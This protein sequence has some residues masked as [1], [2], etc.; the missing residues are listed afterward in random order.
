MSD[1]YYTESLPAKQNNIM[2][3]ALDHARRGWPVFP[4]G[5]DKQPLTKHGFKDASLDPAVIRNWFADPA[6]KKIGLPTGIN[7]WALDV[8]R[9]NGVDG[10]LTLETLQNGETFT[11]GPAQMTPSGGY[12]LFFA[13]PPDMI[14]P[15]NAGQIGP[16]L[17]L[18]GAGGYVCTGPGYTWFDGYPPDAPLSQAPSWLLTAIRKLKAPATPNKATGLTPLPPAGDRTDAAGYW[19]T[20]A[21]ARAAVGNRNATGFDLACQLRDAGLSMGEAESVMRQYAGQV[22]QSAGN[23]YG[24]GEAMATL[25]SAYAAPRREAATLPGGRKVLR[26]DKQAVREA[27][28]HALEAGAQPLTP[29]GPDNFPDDGAPGDPPANERSKPVKA[30]HAELAD[31]FKAARPGR[32]FG[33]GEYRRYVNGIWTVTAADTVM[34]DVLQFLKKAGS[35]AGNITQSTV[36]SVTELY[37]LSIVIP[38]DVWDSGIDYLPCHN[39]VLHIPTHKLLPHSPKYYFTSGLPYDFDPAADCQTFKRVIETACPDAADFLQEFSGYALTVDTKHELAV[40][41]YGPPGGGKSTFV[42]GLESMLGARSG[43]LSLSDIERSTFA[44]TNVIGRTLIQSTEQ[45]AL[46]VQASDKINSLISGETLSVDRKYKEPIQ[47]T[48]RAKLLW[49][50][51]ALPVLSDANNGLFR[52]VKI[53]KFPPV[54]DRDP[55]VKAAIPGEAAGILNWALTG[56]ARLRDR[57]RFD[58]P[59]SVEDATATWKTDNDLAALFIDDRCEVGREYRCRSAELYTA[60]RAWCEDN[61]HRNIKSSKSVRLDFERLGFDH[62]RLPDTT[63]WFG[64]KVKML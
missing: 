43:H 32:A 21:L 35:L 12:Q 17:D 42:L 20:W 7:F 52:R 2:A 37:R 26:T 13:L 3:A 18:R 64:V 30:D 63:Y 15:S 24:D 6:A 14:V 28:K 41:L 31:M 59:Q 40:W 57:G 23:P 49:A 5:P 36:K 16:G 45:P 58:C 19:L 54:K 10:H 51:N 55:A 53:V 8:D 62:K 25:K 44:L 33:L 60:Y 11:V 47:L 27:A 4:C 1:T 61:G 9:K 39:G 34:A 56:L 50:M 48:P 38:D 46:Y 29:P 22:Q